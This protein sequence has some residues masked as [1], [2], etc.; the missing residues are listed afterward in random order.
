MKCSVV[1]HSH[2]LLQAYVMQSLVH[3]FPVQVQHISIVM[4]A[5]GNLW[6]LSLAGISF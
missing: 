2:N 6:H 1:F 3:V 5:W 4:S